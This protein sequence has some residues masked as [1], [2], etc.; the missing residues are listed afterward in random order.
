VGALSRHPIKVRGL[1]TLVIVVAKTVHTHHNDRARRAA[2]PGH[3]QNK[4]QQLEQALFHV[5]NMGGPD[6]KLNGPT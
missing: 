3:G 2:A 5:R 6:P 4:E 1:D